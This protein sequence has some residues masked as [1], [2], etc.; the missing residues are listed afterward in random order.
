[1]Y[2]SLDQDRDHLEWSRGLPQA[3]PTGHPL[4]GNCYSDPCHDTLVLPVLELHINGLI[5]YMSRVCFLSCNIISM[6]FIQ[7]VA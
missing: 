1:M 5:L 3:P 2:Q 7:V 4:K 6:R